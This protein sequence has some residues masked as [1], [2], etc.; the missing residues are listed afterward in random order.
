M[1][2]ESSELPGIFHGDP[3][4]RIL[5]ATARILELTLATILAYGKTHRVHTLKI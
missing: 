4:D 1:V 3:A 5:A 2:V